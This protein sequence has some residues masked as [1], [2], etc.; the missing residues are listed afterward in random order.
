[1]ASTK[2][3]AVQ[4]LPCTARVLVPASGFAHLQNQVSGS[5]WPGNLAGRRSAE[6]TSAREEF[7]QLSGLVCPHP[8][9]R[10]ELK[11]YLMQ[12]V[13]PSPSWPQSL[14]LGVAWISSFSLAS[15]SQRHNWSTVEQGPWHHLTGKASE[16]AWNLHDPPN[17]EPRGGEQS[18]R[19]T[20]QQQCLCLAREL[21]AQ[22]GLRQLSPQK[23]TPVAFKLLLLY[24]SRET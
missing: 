16:N 3:L 11:L 12:R 17:S 21:G 24:Q 20:E 5:V 6:F 15:R 13:A 8:G 2:I 10:A 14:L 18:W 9:G 7:Y 19:P 4:V 23:R 1:M 22:V